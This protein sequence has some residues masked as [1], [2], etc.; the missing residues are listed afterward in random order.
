M[1]QCRACVV[2]GIRFFVNQEEY[3]PVFRTDNTFT[4]QEDRGLGICLT[5]RYVGRF[6]DTL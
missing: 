2:L 6:S 1:V 3:F 4:I 5:L